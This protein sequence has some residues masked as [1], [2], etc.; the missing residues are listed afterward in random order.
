MFQGD[1]P[2]SFR[3][4][5]KGRCACEDTFTFD[6]DEGECN[7]S[8]DG[9]IDTAAGFAKWVVIVVVVSIFVMLCCCVA[10]ACIIF[11]IFT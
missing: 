9:I 3:E 1:W 5:A 10:V 4:E 7:H 8:L 6:K 11:K 2:T